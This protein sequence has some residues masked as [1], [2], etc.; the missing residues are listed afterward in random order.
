M[1]EKPS[2]IRLLII[3]TVAVRIALISAVSFGAVSIGAVCSSAAAADAQQQSESAR[4]ADEKWVE[5]GR[6]A[7]GEGYGR[8]WYDGQQDRAA[9]WEFASRTERTRRNTTIIPAFGPGC[10]PG[11]GAY[12]SGLFGSRSRSF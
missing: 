6:E 12:C 7:L 8:R 9:P 5:R 10:L 11:W 3:R 2:S 1:P 4:A